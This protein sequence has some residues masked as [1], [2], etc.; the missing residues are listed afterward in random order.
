MKLEK[1]AVLMLF[2]MFGCGKEDTIIIKPDVLVLSQDCNPKNAWVGSWQVTHIEGLDTLTWIIQNSQDTLTNHDWDT[3]SRFSWRIAFQPDKTWYTTIHCRL[4]WS[5]GAW[6]RSTVIFGGTYKVTDNTFELTIT[7]D[8][9]ENN[10]DMNLYALA[11]V[12]ET[13]EQYWS[14]KMNDN[15]LGLRMFGEFTV[16]QE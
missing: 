3:I 13:Q 8:D 6:Q 11:K 2:L 15:C 16:T 4:S 5:N 10:Y 12:V 7:E 1:I 9:A 14:A